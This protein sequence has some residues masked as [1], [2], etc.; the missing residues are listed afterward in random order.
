[1]PGWNRT[2]TLPFISIRGSCRLAGPLDDHGSG[3]AS[4][5]FR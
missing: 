4:V 2:P 3:R 5:I 1:M